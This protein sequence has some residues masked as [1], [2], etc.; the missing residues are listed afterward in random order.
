MILWKRKS[1]GAGFDFLLHI[2][3]KFLH[4]GGQLKRDISISRFHFK[5]GGE[6][7]I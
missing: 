6:S 1:G 4:V 5:I 3:L 7:K 2:L